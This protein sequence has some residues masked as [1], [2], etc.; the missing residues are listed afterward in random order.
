MTN[1][2]DK[3]DPELSA[4]AEYVLDG[5]AASAPA[6]EMAH[7]AVFDFLGCALKALDEPGCRRAIEPIVPDAIVPGGARVPGTSYEFD[8]ATAA[9]AIGTMGRWLDF[10]DSWFGKG[11]GHPSDMWGA[12]LGVGDYLARR[13]Q[14]LSMAPLLELGIKAYEIM[15]LHL[16]DN[17][18]GPYDYTAPLKAAT[19]AVTCRLLGGGAAEIVNAV[20]QGWADGQPL[21]I[22]RYPYTT[23]RK[24]WGSP[25]AASRGVWHAYRAVA[26]EAGFPKVL[27]VPEVG[28]IDAEQKGVPFST[29]APYGSHVMENILFKVY[30]AQFRAQTA[31]EAV[32]TLHGEVRDR[33]DD[34]ACVDVFTHDRALR[35][36]DKR[37]P[38]SSASERDHC[39]QYIVA[40]GLIHGDLEYSYYHDEAAADPQVDRLREKIELRERSEYTAGFSDPETRSDASAVQVFFADDSSTEEVEV[41]YPLGDRRRREAAGPVLA[42]KFRRNIAGQ[43]SARNEELVLALFDDPER[44][45]ALGVDEFMAMLAA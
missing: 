1:F 27:S 44:F 33:L 23:P 18:F 34:I 31:M 17:E 41:L 28:L 29:P 3:A 11:G 40:V 35:T 38:L 7:L 6:Y 36:V 39:M 13:G 30:P 16:S 4:I 45:R 21:R 8:P 9:F 19:A 25:D 10:N 2:D 20:S 12:I 26:G 32:I 22:Y 24:N 37:G 43:L 42:D 14:T 5:Q 15:G